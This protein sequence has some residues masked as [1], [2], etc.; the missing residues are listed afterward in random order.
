MLIVFSCR[1]KGRWQK[2]T[3]SHCRPASGPAC[4]HH[5][6]KR[7]PNMG[8]PLFDSAR[9]VLE[10]VPMLGQDAVLDPHHVGGDPCGGLSSTRKASV[11]GD[12]VAFRENEAVLI[13][14]AVGKAADEPEQSFAAGFDM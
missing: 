7:S 8:N 9:L 1:T 4:L 12:V 11:D 3:G 13:A 2:P 6:G 10:H 5:A 14:Q